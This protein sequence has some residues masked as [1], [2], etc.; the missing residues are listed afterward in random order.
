MSKENPYSFTTNTHITA[1]TSLGSALN[2][3]TTLS[4]IERNETFS[5]LITISFFPYNVYN[6]NSISPLIFLEYFKIKYAYSLITE[7]I[8]N[9]P[10]NI[11]QIS[12]IEIPDEPPCCVRQCA[13][14]FFFLLGVITL[15]A[16]DL[17]TYCSS[18]G[19]L[20]FAHLGS[21][22]LIAHI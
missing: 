2:Y 5:Y 13:S 1:L 8:I 15:S 16:S 6:T 4:F 18:S 20:F 22:Y 21:I 14:T 10:Q 12:F 17:Q 9:K 19:S 7:K 11:I 3:T